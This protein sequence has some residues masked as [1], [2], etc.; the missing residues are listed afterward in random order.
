MSDS[1]D[2]S[3]PQL[4]LLLWSHRVID[5]IEDNK[6]RG[7]S[8]AIGLIE[9]NVGLVNGWKAIVK[10]V[11]LDGWL[12]KLSWNLV[13]VDGLTS[14]YVEQ[15]VHVK[16]HLVNAVSHHYTHTSG[17][18]RSSPSPWTGELLCE[19]NKCHFLRYCCVVVWANSHRSRAIEVVGE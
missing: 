7:L 16:T 9:G 11:R 8:R 10:Y 13:R 15:V 1:D 2:S 12:R 19:S 4:N 17:V 18:N 5:V 3:T 6:S 14:G